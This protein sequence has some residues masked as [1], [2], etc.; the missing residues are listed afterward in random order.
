MFDPPHGLRLFHQ[1]EGD[2]GGG[3]D[4]QDL[5]FAGEALGQLADD[6]HR[7][8]LLGGDAGVHQAAVAHAVAAVGVHGGEGLAQQGACLLYTS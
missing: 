3:P 2:V 1:G 4:H 5:Q 8:A 7:V 6:V